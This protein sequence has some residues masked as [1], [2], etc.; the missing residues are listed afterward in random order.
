M[1]EIINITG[2]KKR[3]L[4]TS[5]CI[6]AALAMLAGMIGIE[7]PQSV[8]AD[9]ALAPGI[10][11]VLI[12][13]RY[14]DNEAP[15]RH[16]IDIGD[17]LML[18]VNGGGSVDL[19]F[20]VNAY[21]KY[22]A[23]YMVK[24]EKNDE[25]DALCGAYY[26]H[27]SPQKNK[28][29][30]DWKSFDGGE[31]TG[32]D[33]IDG[34]KD[35]SLNDCFVRLDKP[36]SENIDQER[37][38][39]TFV[40]KNF[41]LNKKIGFIG[42]TGKFLSEVPSIKPSEYIKSLVFKVDV[43]DIKGNDICYLAEGYAED[44][45]NPPQIYPL[46]T[47]YM[48]YNKNLLSSVPQK[49]P[50]W[51]VDFSDK[52]E[53]MTY[54]LTPDEENKINIDFVLTDEYKGMNPVIKKVVGRKSDALEGST[55]YKGYLTGHSGLLWSENLYNKNSGTVSIPLSSSEF[56]YGVRLSFEKDGEYGGETG[57]LFFSDAKPDEAVTINDA[58]TGITYK[59]CT[60]NIR[61]GA[62]LSVSKVESGFIYDDFKK[63]AIDGKFQVWNLSIKE[64]GQAFIPK[65]EGRV[66]IPIPADWDTNKFYAVI[67][68]KC[69]I[70]YPDSRMDIVQIGDDKYFEYKDEGLIFAGLSAF[71]PENVIAIGEIKRKLDVSALGAGVYKVE[72][73]F[74]KYGTESQGSM[75]GGTLQKE[76]Y[77]VVGIDGSKEVYLNF[78]PIV[79]E[80]IEAHMATLWNKSD[81][82]VTLFDFV[83][84]ANGALLSN[85]DF[86]PNS[87]FACLKSA[88]IKLSDDTYDSE[89]FKYHFY[90]IPPAMGSG[91]PFEDVYN[92]P[93]DADLVFYS[94]EK[95]DGFDVDMIPTFQKSVLRRSVDKA[96]SLK[97][98]DYTAD[99]YG[100][101]KTALT[102]GKAYYQSLGAGDAGADKTISNA[103]KEK[104]DA[105][106]T[107]IKEL[108][109]TGGSGTNPG[110]DPGGT[111]PQSSL[112]IKTLKNGEYTIRG[113]MM[114]VN[115]KS[116][117]MSD[118]AID[119]D[120]KLTV[121]DG[122]YTIT[123]NFHGMKYLGRFGYLQKL[124][125]FKTGY[126][127]NAHGVP[128]GELADVTVNSWHLNSDGGKLSDEYGTDYPK[129]LS[130]ELIPE[131]KDDGWVPLQ[132]FVPVM[133]ALGM[134]DNNPGM[135]TQQ[136]YLKLD[137][138]S[139][140]EGAPSSG[141]TGG[142]GETAVPEVIKK[143]AGKKDD[144]FD[145]LT[146]V[147]NHW[148]KESIAYVIEKNLFKGI[149]STKFEPEADMTRSMVV[150]V[151]HRMAGTPSA[152]ASAA[153]SDVK[154]GA[155]Y[156]SAVNWAI[157]KNI[158]KGVGNNIFAPNASI[159]REAFVTML[160]NY[161]KAHDPE[162]GKSKDIS[163][164]SDAGEVSPWASDAMKWASG[165]GFIK[166]NNKGQ[167][168]PKSKITRAEVATIFQRYLKSV[169]ISKA[170]KEK[171]DKK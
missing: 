48:K 89:T 44:E 97:A 74:L 40:V 111:N 55:A 27:T 32:Y 160:Y 93:L 42:Y 6:L 62:K 148:A 114:R 60:A 86:N 143:D 53:S 72:P 113:D 165:S 52:F 144:A 13:P 127:E 22:E 101:L 54:R 139:I 39:A 168:S 71:N 75:S 65:R 38:T 112:D 159:T 11:N 134:E 145:K 8:S 96:E 68:G 56:L 149:S 91:Q 124:Q 92:N 115:K 24:Q 171:S 77:L 41:D 152:S 140:S 100:K 21:S 164:Y 64:D 43:K 169:E 59:S 120:I 51:K 156:E 105:I 83:T 118:G 2:V 3:V 146:D 167:L 151:L 166:G 36:T 135:G 157:N 57:I 123:M 7:P 30:T 107:A 147:K 163:E 119:H 170:A 110:T 28:I 33:Q 49:L 102:A 84:D 16:C 95:L 150:T 25:I 128:E 162:L 73:D 104:S 46:L 103:I 76:G 31:L 133:E 121:D 20:Q 85:S 155:W 98:A 78:K 154:S 58:A 122:T 37:D 129:E 34:M 137:L 29:G 5:L 82:N 63:K 1:K 79:K 67:S 9:N 69:Y 158:V 90:V 26:Y 47:S 106:E 10:Y 4:R 125:Y 18:I 131:A 50:R 142:G 99:S 61:K 87:E 108:K 109:K 136:V 23:I 138:K 17:R 126:T 80:G 88:K 141:T 15:H 94:A 66:L 70:M 45:D 12:T 161:A 35:A 132:V 14:W 116:K 130:Y 153:L 117:S 81:Q 19:V